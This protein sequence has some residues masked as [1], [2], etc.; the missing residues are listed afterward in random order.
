MTDYW[1]RTMTEDGTVRALAAITTTAVEKA[2]RRHGTAPTATAA[3][4]RTLTAAGLIGAMLKSGQTVTVRILGD[5]PLGGVLA[6]GD[7]AGSVRGYVANPGVHLPLTPS[8]KLD[9]GGAVGRGTLH[10]TMDLGMRYPYHGSV[11][12]V[13]GEIGED[14]AAYFVRSQ[15]IPSLVAL[16]VLVSPD[17]R[18]IASGGLIVQLM[19]GAD[20]HT[21]AYLE[22]RAKVLPTITSMVSAGRSPEEILDTALGEVRTRVVARQ[23]VRFACRC[24]RRRVEGVLVSLGERELREIVQEQGQVEVRCNFCGRRYLLDEADVHAL[25]ER[26]GKREPGTGNG[27]R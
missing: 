17:E 23:V 13:S 12:L 6:T 11:P 27:E 1:V 3:L 24:S 5:G 22:E 19:P 26:W 4:G 15:Q 10:V 2:R 14:L 7:A 16:G 9:V 20:N 8:R 21:A 25:I 18:V